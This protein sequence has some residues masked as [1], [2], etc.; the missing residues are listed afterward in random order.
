MKMSGRVARIAAPNVTPTIMTLTT[1]R[2][3]MVVR[4]RSAAARCMP[5][6]RAGRPGGFGGDVGRRGGLTSVM[7]APLETRATPASVPA[8]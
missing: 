2:R 5:D 3:L 7:T 1:R 4:V 8:R 6:G